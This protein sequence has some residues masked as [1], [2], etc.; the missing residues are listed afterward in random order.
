M[1]CLHAERYAERL[2]AE[3]YAER[4]GIATTPEESKSRLA[5][6]TNSSGQRQRSA[7]PR[8]PTKSPRPTTGNRTRTKSIETLKRGGAR[9]SKMAP[10]KNLSSAGASVLK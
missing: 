6:P 7:E 4:S 5:V 3:R 2:H 1:V 8:T 10:K 9:P